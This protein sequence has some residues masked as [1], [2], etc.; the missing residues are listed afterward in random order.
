MPGPLSSQAPPSSRQEV[1]VASHATN[2]KRPPFLS[3]VETKLHPDEATGESSPPRQGPRASSGRQLDVSLE[4]A[5]E[6]LPLLV[7]E[8]ARLADLRV[9]D[10]DVRQAAE[11]HELVVPP[12]VARAGRPPRAEEDGD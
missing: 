4:G 5:L 12:G 9:L 1:V 7:G 11:A 10:T 3:P 8:A 6:A 2:A